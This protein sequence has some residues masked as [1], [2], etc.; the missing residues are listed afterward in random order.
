MEDWT[1]ILDWTARF[2]EV[3]EVGLQ[4]KMAEFADNDIRTDDQTTCN[5]MLHAEA[6]VRRRDGGQMG[7]DD[8]AGL[9]RFNIR[10]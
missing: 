6:A 5:L 4:S 7:G 3:V 8:E 10:D 1:L 9:V 2:C